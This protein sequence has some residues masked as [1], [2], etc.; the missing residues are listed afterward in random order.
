MAIDELNAKGFTING[1][2]VTLQL[3]PRTTAPIRSKARRW[4][5]SW[6]TPRSTA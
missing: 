6:S 3:L 2:K 5:R 1:Q 4:R